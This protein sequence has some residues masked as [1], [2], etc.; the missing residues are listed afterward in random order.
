MVKR[1]VF[2]IIFFLSIFIFP[3]WVSILL[4]FLGIFLFKNFY[5]FIIINTIIYLLYS[6]PNNRLIAS[7][8]F[9][10]STII[11]SFLLIEFIKSNII[12]YRKNEI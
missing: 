12:L 11:L 10:S 3:W 1:V 5:E 6:V 8:I 4:S 9:F 7:P 2:D